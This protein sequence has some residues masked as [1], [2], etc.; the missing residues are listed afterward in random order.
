MV[1]KQ[2][3][4]RGITDKQILSAFLKVERHNFI[5]H[6][7]LNDAYRD[8]AIPIGEGQTISRP[9]IIAIMI[10]VI[11]PDKDK[12]ILEVGTGTGYQTAL[13]AEL[14]KD[15]FSIEIDP[16]LSAMAAG[17]LKQTEYR[18]IH[19]RTGDGYVGWKEHAPFDAIIVDCA[20]DHI[21][22]ALLDQLAPGGRMVLPVSYA[23]NVQELILIEKTSAGEFKRKN[24]IPVQFVPLIRGNNDKQTN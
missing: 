13:L 24:L 19:L 18:N 2:I 20:P 22:Q 15:V 21:P 3:L 16:N 6:K 1:S 4:S 14:S 23:S 11:K 7:F 17:N 12:K 8:A 10:S 9:Y 5:K